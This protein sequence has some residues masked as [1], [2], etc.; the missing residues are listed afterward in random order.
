MPV[1]TDR[2]GS[3]GARSDWSAICQINQCNIGRRRAIGLLSA[4]KIEEIMGAIC[5]KDGV[6]TGQWPG[7]FT[8]FL[9]L[10]DRSP[11]VAG[12]GDRRHRRDQQSRGEQNYKQA[13]EYAQMFH[14]A[15]TGRYRCVEGLNTGPLHCLPEKYG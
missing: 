7:D 1:D 2:Q 6:S 5:I 14:R 11:L 13:T 9:P 12:P 10:V 8:D 15:I 3:Y 4:H